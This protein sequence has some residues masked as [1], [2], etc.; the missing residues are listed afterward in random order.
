[1][2]HA[3]T[4]TGKT[5]LPVKLVRYMVFLLV[6]GCSSNSLTTVCQKSSFSLSKVLIYKE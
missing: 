4:M 5:E 1:M 6:S 3:Q 2:G